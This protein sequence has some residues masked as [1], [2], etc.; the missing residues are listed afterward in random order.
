MM[1]RLFPPVSR[2]IARA[3]RRAALP[4][5]L[6]M[7]GLLLGLGLAPLCSAAVDA[8]Q[9]R[10][11][12][13]DFI[14]QQRSTLLAGYADD[15]RLEYRINNLDPRLRLADCDVP[16]ALSVKDPTAGSRLNVH[17][18]CPGSARWAIYVPV[19]I[20]VWQPVVVVTTPIAR[21]QTLTAAELGVAEQDVAA[22]SLSYY[23]DPATVVGF[24]ARRVLSANSPVLASQVEAPLQVKRGDKVILTAMQG[25][26]QVKMDGVA[27]QDGRYG[28]RISVRNSRSQRLIEGRVTG[29][30]QVQV[31]M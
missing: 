20:S 27:E 30:G 21:G 25:S 26:L 23:S 5:W 14:G 17:V 10:Q 24:V 2:P 1:C 29:P 7:G 3:R 8:R 28:D 19:E 15:A 18:S 6:G 11:A 16:L 22:N 12:V 9:L 31:N 13:A 4:T